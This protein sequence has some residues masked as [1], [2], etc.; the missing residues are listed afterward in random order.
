ME[1]E[2]VSCALACCLFLTCMHV[3]VPLR[4]PL[5]V[6]VCA[7]WRALFLDGGLISWRAE[8]GN[9]MWLGCVCPRWIVCGWPIDLCTIFD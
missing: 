1:A 4:V 6:R 5:L 8:K 2:C 9:L 7:C 3:C